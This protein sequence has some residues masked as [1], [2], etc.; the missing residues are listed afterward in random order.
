MTNT[1]VDRGNVGVGLRQWIYQT[2]T[3]FGYCGYFFIHK[4]PTS[5][6]FSILSSLHTCTFISDQSCDVNST[7]PFSRYMGLEPN[8]DICKEVFQVKDHATYGRVDFTNSYYGSNQPRGTRIV[9][10]NGEISF[11]VLYAHIAFL[12]ILDSV[13]PP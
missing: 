2:C 9:F 7:C 8:L 3:Q 11:S 5:F 10:V 6:D 13:Y 4:D 1:T 12:C